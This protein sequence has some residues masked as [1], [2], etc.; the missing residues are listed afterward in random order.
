M[1]SLDVRFEEARNHRVDDLYRVKFEKNSEKGLTLRA[2]LMVKLALTADGIF[3]LA[4][5]D[6]N[7]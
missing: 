3:E 6:L 7:L 4:N 1:R 2:H 5:G